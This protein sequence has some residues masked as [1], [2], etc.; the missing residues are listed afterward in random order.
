MPET[1]SRFEPTY[2]FSSDEKAE[3]QRL[4]SATLRLP[5]RVVCALLAGLCAVAM[6]FTAFA[7]ENLIGPVTKLPL[8]R[9][10]SLKSDKVNLREGASKEHRTKYIYQRAG[11]PVEVI[12]EFENWRR[13]RDS[14]GVEGWVWQSLL[15]SK[16][17]ILVAPWLKDKPVPLYD[18]A[19]IQSQV[20]A[21]LMPN[22]LANVKFCAD[23]WCRIIGEGFDGYIEKTQVWG[24]YQDETVD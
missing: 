11:L 23:A 9:F 21:Q 18:R 16:R 12:S 14:E 2:L 17:T 8:P 6:P 22:V 4:R 3:K 5:K 24:V 7:G 10:V 20:N 13:I 15:S 1:S 19:N